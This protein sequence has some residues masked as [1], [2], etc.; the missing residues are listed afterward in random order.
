VEEAPA[1]R[2][3]MR[4]VKGISR[5]NVAGMETAREVGPFTSVLDVWGRAG[6]S[7]AVMSRLAA[8]VG[9]VA[10]LHV[11]GIG[12]GTSVTGRV[13]EAPNSGRPSAGAARPW[14]INVAQNGWPGNTDAR[15]GETVGDDIC[16]SHAV[17][18]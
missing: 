11:M 13:L 12:T 3:G 17:S 7:R 10:S 1:L 15:G 4:L 5:E 16:Y 14:A 18:M 9:A 6:V 2:L 8:A